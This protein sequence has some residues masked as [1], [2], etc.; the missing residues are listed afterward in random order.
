[1]IKC[2][3]GVAVAAAGGVQHRVVGEI[4]VGV[5]VAD[6]THQHTVMPTCDRTDEFT[7]SRGSDRDERVAQ[8]VA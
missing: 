8:I 3:E 4:R 5:E 6:G 2:L 7:P 1:V